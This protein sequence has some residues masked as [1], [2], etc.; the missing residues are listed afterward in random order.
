M[1]DDLA[2]LKEEIE[3]ELNMVKRVNEY[4]NE[5]ETPAP[6]LPKAQVVVPFITALWIK[7]LPLSILFFG[8]AFVSWTIVQVVF[9]GRYH[10]AL[11][12]VEH[13]VKVLEEELVKAKEGEAVEYW[14]HQ[15]DFE[16]RRGDFNEQCRDVLGKP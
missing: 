7:W 16:V 5:P 14:A 10:E 11:G 6:D 9:V 2:T 13:R 12:R 1:P 3:E 8:L 15:C 4:A